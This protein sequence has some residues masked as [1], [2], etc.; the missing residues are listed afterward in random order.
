MKNTKALVAG[1]IPSSFVDGPGNRYVIF[2]QGC[3]LR[4]IYC[5][6]PETH[7][8]EG[9]G[10]P[11]CK[12][13]TLEDLLNEVNKYVD[14]ISGVTLSGG[15]PLV[16]WRFVIEFSKEFKKR[17]PNKTVLIDTNA[18]L[19]REVLEAVMQY[20]DYFSPDIKA[21]DPETYSKITG[22]LGNFRRLLKNIEI[23]YK[24]GKIYEVRLPIVPGFTD[25]KESMLLWVELLEQ[26]L[27]RDIRIRIIKFRPYGVKTALSKAESPSEKLMRS[28]LELLKSRGFYRIHY[29]GS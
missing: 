8:I 20:V 14:L 22:G 17:Y 23:L 19:D 7:D 5:Q 6:N 21:P 10:N 3:N 29:L 27:S 24:K 11:L 4:C 9:R 13:M 15:E 28:F 26:S 18:D 25:N 2:M 1:L 16:Q 12:W